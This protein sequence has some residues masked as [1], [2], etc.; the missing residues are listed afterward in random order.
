MSIKGRTWINSDGRRNFPSGEVFTGPEETSAEGTIRFTF[1]GIYIGKEVEDISL[2]FEKGTVVKA[3]AKKGDDFLQE[4]LN[5]DEGARRI[6]EIAVG[7]NYGITTF[8]K[9]IL[10]DEK[11]GGTIHLALGRSIP[12]SGGKNQSAI[13]WDLIKDMKNNGKLYADGE[14]FYENG[15]VLI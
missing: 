7:T 11:I 13:H 3:H 12:D 4:M 14:L 2:T 6:G 10:F 5:T 15:K 9:N 8:T 1:P